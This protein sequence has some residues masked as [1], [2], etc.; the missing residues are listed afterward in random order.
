MSRLVKH[1]AELLQCSSARLVQYTAWWIVAR[2]VAG[3][4]ASLEVRV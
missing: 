1:L 2:G 3:L 4:A